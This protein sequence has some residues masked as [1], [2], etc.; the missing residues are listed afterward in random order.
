MNFIFIS[1]E[2]ESYLLGLVKKGRWIRKE[3]ASLESKEDNLYIARVVQELKGQRAYIIE[4]E[5]HEKGFLPYNQTYSSIK[6]G[7]EILVQYIKKGKDNKFPRFT[8][9]YMI[10]GD[11]IHLTPWTKEIRVSRKAKH[12]KIFDFEEKEY[13]MI[14]RREG[15]TK[16]LEEIEREYNDL[17]NIE[18]RIEKE[19]HFLPIPRLILKQNKQIVQ[20][21]NQYS[22]QIDYIKTN[23]KI[24]KNIIEEKSGKDLIIDEH[25]DPYYDSA[26]QRDLYNIENKRIKIDDKSEIVFE[27]TEA[28]VSVDV[29]HRS[30]TEKL[31]DKILETN[32]KAVYEMAIQMELRSLTGIAVVDCINMNQEMKKQFIRKTNEII[33][34]FPKLS[35]HGITSLNL[36]QF[37]RTGV[38]LIDS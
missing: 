3:T 38:K 22:T 18:K 14:L 30:S 33:K 2:K 4:Y 7:D 32:I 20:F 15:I 27:K 9:K 26:L 5:K 16:S 37:I 24:F 31:G 12:K 10:L 35:F 28:L 6:P 8:Q 1:K 19:K 36:A 13:G 23:D 21:I 34:E 29:N 25:Y 17:S 11:N